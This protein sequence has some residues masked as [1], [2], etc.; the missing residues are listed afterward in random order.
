[1]GNG[2][3]IQKLNKIIEVTQ[4]RSPIVGMCVWECT[5]AVAVATGPAPWRAIAAGD[6]VDDT[7]ALVVMAVGH[8]LAVVG[9]A[10]RLAGGVELGKGDGDQ[11]R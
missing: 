7:L 1:M 2:V 9:D 3:S 5:K 10:L 6:W 11:A 8:R 4:C